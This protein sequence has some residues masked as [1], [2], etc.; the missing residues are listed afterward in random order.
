MSEELPRFSYGLPDINDNKAWFETDIEDLKNHIAHGATPAE[1][2]FLCRAGTLPRRKTSASS[3][4]R[5]ARAGSR[6]HRTT[7]RANEHRRPL[8]DRHRRHDAHVSRH[9]RGRVGSRDKF[10][11]EAAQ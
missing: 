6:N 11:D 3:G 2:A 1:T 4:K 9:Y 8:R 5:A 10:Q 7:I